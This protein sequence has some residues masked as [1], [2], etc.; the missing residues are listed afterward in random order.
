[1]QS[2]QLDLT[3]KQRK[4]V[5]VLVAT[6]NIAEAAR[7]ASVKRSTVYRW[8]EQENF[9]RALREAETEAIRALARRMGAMAE[10]ATKALSDALTDENIRIRLKAA[11][12]YFSRLIQLRQFALLEDRIRDLEKQLGVEIPR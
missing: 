5:E 8:R 7:E 3:P 6:G 12:V 4:A 10:Q 2:Y 1:M 11:D 9:Q